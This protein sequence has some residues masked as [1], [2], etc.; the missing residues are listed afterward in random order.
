MTT[1]IS[2]RA[3]SP[4]VVAI[5]CVV[6]ALAIPADAV[7]FYLRA[8]EVTVTMPD[9]TMVP[10]WGFALDTDGDFGT[11]EN[12]AQVPGP[13]LTVPV[14]DT[15]VNIYVHNA[16]DVAQ[17]VSLVIQGQASTG[18]PVRFAPTDPYYPDRIRSFT[19]ET[20]QGT[21][22][23]Y[24]WSAFRHGTFL[25]K[26]G[27]QLQ[28]QVPMGLY[29]AITQD[30]GV[31]GEAYSGVTYTNEALLLYSEIDP[32]LNAAVTTP[33][34]YGPTG[35]LMTSTLQYKPRY[36]L[37]NGQP[38]DVTAPIEFTGFVVGEP[39]LLRL[40]SAALD[41][42]VPTLFGGHWDLVAEDGFTLPHPLSQS[43]T[44]LP[45]SKTRD[46]VFTPDRSGA[47]PIVDRALD[48]TNAAATEGGMLAHLI[49]D[50]PPG[51]PYG[52]ADTYAVD[53][54]DSLTVDGTTLPSVL[55]NDSDGGPPG[56][57]PNVATEMQGV[58]HGSLSFSSDGTFSYTPDADFFGADFFLYTF[59]DGDSDSE[60]VTVTIRVDPVNDAPVAVNDTYSGF[61]DLELVIG[62]TGVLMNDIDVDGDALT[63]LLT[64][65]PDNG[66]VSLLSDGSFAYTGDPEFS[67]IDSF[68]YE[69]RDA[70]TS[71]GIA[72]V[73]LNIAAVN[74][75]PVAQVDVYPTVQQDTMFVRTA[76][77]VLSN[78]SDVEGSTL[79]AVLDRG[80]LHGA[81]TLSPD[82]SLTY[83]PDPSYVG[84][85]FFLYRANDGSLNSLARRVW[86]FTNPIFY[87]GF[88]S[89]A[90]AWSG[91]VK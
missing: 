52:T 17:P 90:D 32:A 72:T 86:L 44:P 56:T 11:I 4:L 81:L 34:G 75:P 37:I 76:P 6:A 13:R 64:D 62:D 58:L 15:T 23:L 57:G 89:G 53:E 74:D 22:E 5:A 21:T 9:G 33:G 60:P 55:D 38:W 73:T 41:N 83:M 28:V 18:Q 78:D 45:P 16:L 69:A 68:Q 87:N 26:S 88:E 3:Y 42:H 91:A 71:G 66:S 49:V 54:D 59:N 84:S 48:L 67:G 2:T 79:S 27:T 25:Y 8:D 47:Y 63:A 31:A 80:P 85:D 7:D 30:F 46:I 36:F 70:T 43:A 12:P 82:G 61:E 50:G 65:A 24:T 20:A 1:P 14:G 40:L 29:G 19:H 51:A 39:G 35:T 77:G 10:M